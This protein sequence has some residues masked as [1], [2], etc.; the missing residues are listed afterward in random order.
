MIHVGMTGRLLSLFG[1]VWQLDEVVGSNL[2]C[3]WKPGQ[4]DTSQHQ[5]SEILRLDVK[6]RWGP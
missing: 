6:D 1:L 4:A 5:V 2:A 3:T